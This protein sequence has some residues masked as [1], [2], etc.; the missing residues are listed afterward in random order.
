MSKKSM[1]DDEAMKNSSINNNFINQSQKL[2]NLPYSSLRVKGDTH[3]KLN[4]LKKLE[5]ADAI[6]DVLEK[7]IELYIEKL[8][9]EKKEEIQNLVNQEND[10]KIK[11]ARKKASSRK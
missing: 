11:K 4:V 6:D 8:P 9:K 3:S 2:E 10:Y 5:M 1:I 7:A